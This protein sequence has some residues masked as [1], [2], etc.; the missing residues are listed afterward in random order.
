MP[1]IFSLFSSLFSL[2]LFVLALG[3]AEPADS[4]WSARYVIT[5]DAQRRVIENGAVA[6]K[7]DRILAVGTKASGLPTVSRLRA[8]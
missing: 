5:M 6:I 2:F 4:I 1:R 8:V 7:G 3:A